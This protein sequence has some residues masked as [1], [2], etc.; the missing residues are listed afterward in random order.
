MPH[1][2][3]SFLAGH[4]Q[5]GLNPLD[6]GYI[7]AIEFGMLSTAMIGP[8]QKIWFGR[9]LYIFLTRLSKAIH[10]LEYK[11]NDFPATRLLSPYM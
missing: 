9:K 6:N 5:A 10:F 2:M 8:E 3:N 4:E 1:D 11:T 7:G